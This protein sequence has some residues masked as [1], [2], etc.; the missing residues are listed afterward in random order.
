ML[1]TYPVVPLNPFAIC[2]GLDIGDPVFIFQIPQHGFSNVGFKAFG[3]SPTEFALD[4]A[5]IN[6]VSTIMAR[7]ISN[8]GNLLAGP[9]AISTSV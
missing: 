9:F 2:A 8:V 1:V 5:G 4:F 6:G 3:R 7:T